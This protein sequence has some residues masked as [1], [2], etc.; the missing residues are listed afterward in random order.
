MKIINKIVKIKNIIPSYLEYLKQK[1][2][3]KKKHIELKERALVINI[4]N[5]AVYHRYFYTFLKF[6]S[7]EGFDIF[8]PICNY[9]FYRRNFYDRNKNSSNYFNLIFKEG[10]LHFKKP[11]KNYNFIYE[12]NDTNLSLDY[13]TNLLK[14]KIDRYYIPMSLHPL[15][16]H[17]DIWNI[18]FLNKK[19][20]VSIFM[21]G[22]IDKK[23]YEF[24]DEESFKMENRYRTYKY[25][26]DKNLIDNIS[27]L[28]E[29][30]KFL[31]SAKDNVCIIIGRNQFEIKMINL[32][33]T[34]SRFY[35]YLVLPGVVM[36]FSHNIAETLS[37]GTIPIIHKEYAKLMQ[38]NLI[39]MENAIIYNDLKDLELKIKFAYTL[40][41]NQ[42]HKLSENAYAY[43]KNNMHPKNVVLRI[44]KNK[45]MYLQAEHSSVGALMN[46]L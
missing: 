28:N 22:C 15:F 12:I 32:R 21:I 20:K 16:Y 36:P 29:L 2:I 5:P 43:Y 23:A 33:E 41:V 13:F 38:P 35:F 26:L 30:N 37:V 3:V 39:H 25:L 14:Q 34:I 4:K 27:S 17:K 40:S 44:I 9:H 45:S 24:F 46:N 18:D 1:R 8:Y 6:F 42:I 19:R 10:L 11:S 7:I 31:N